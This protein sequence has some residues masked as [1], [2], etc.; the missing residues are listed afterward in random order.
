MGPICRDPMFYHDYCNEW[1]LCKALDPGAQVLIEEDKD[2]K[3]GISEDYHMV[4]REPTLPPPYPPPPPFDPYNSMLPPLLPSP[5]PPLLQSHLIQ[6][7]G[8]EIYQANLIQHPISL[9][10]C[11]SGSSFICVMAFLMMQVNCPL[12]QQF[13]IFQTMKQFVS[14]VILSHWYLILPQTPHIS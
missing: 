7:S 4:V 5:S 12:V 9:N 2:N 6:M 10:L 13:S 3:E 11:P 1:D 14:W 8:E